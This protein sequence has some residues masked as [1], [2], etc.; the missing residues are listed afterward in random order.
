MVHP[1]WIEVPQIGGMVE[2]HIESP[3][4]TENSVRA[5]N[6]RFTIPREIIVVST[7]NSLLVA[8]FA[9]ITSI[10]RTRAAP[11]PSKEPTLY[12]ST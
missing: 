5:E 3:V 1:A 11:T 10:F 8:L 12:V 7:M 9:L 6:A 4:A 2:N